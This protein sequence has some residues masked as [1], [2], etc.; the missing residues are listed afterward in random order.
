[1]NIS[2]PNEFNS[3]KNGINNVGLTE[4]NQ[5]F[6]QKVDDQKRIM[7]DQ[8]RGALRAILENSSIERLNRIALVKPDKVLQIEDYILRTARNH[9]Y[10]PYRKIQ[11]SE[12]VEMISMMNE[13]TEKNSSRIKICRKGVFDDD[14][15]EF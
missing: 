9:G 11:E 3:G 7:E 12:L 1:M 10:S 2:D 5:E 4:A 8:K 14:D 13:T 15:Y 6:K